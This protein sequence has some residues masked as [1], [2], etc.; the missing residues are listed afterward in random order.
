MPVA[1][2]DHRGNRRQ[3]PAILLPGTS[4]G[5]EILVMRSLCLFD[6]RIG[7]NGGLGLRYPLR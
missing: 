6:F 4:T 5:K 7:L 2:V 1:G 3:A